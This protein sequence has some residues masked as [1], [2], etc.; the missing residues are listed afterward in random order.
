MST[1][2]ETT[3]NVGRT[4]FRKTV[5]R[6]GSVNYSVGERER[7]RLVG[8]ARAARPD[9]DAFPVT[10][11]YY[12]GVNAGKAGSTRVVFSLTGKRYSPTGMG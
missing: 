10:E 6:N 1:E 4:R 8:L 5:R 2:T 11:I 3:V 7:I 9:L 12:S